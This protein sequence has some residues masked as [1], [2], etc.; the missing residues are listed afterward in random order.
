MQDHF[1]ILTVAERSGP[2]Y[3]KQGVGCIAAHSFNDCPR[4]DVL[5]VPGPLLQTANLSP[6]PL[7]RVLPAF[8]NKSQTCRWCRYKG[9]DFESRAL[10]LDSEHLHGRREAPRIP[11][12]GLH[13]LRSVTS[14][15]T[16]RSLGPDLRDL[17]VNDLIALYLCSSRCQGRT[18]ARSTSHQQ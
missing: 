9:T 11:A 5:I 2:V 13:G 3:S 15:S 4:L 16:A 18:A 6:E 7:A 17:L 8:F 1:T 14:S 12:L 10:G